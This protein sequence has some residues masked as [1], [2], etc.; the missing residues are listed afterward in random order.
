MPTIGVLDVLRIEEWVPTERT[1]FVR[2]QDRRFP[3]DQLRRDGIFELYQRYQGRPIFHKTDYIVSFYAGPQT[4]A[5]FYGVFK[6]NGH[7]PANEGEVLADYP[8]SQRWHDSAK[9]FYDLELLPHARGLRDRL[10]I[11]WGKGTRSWVQK[12]QNRE[13]L[14]IRE[15][16]RSLPPF[17]DYLEFTLSYRQLQDLFRHPEAHHEWRSRLSA[18]AGVYLI[19][20]ETTGH[21]Y[22]GSATGEAGIWGRWNS[23]ATTGHAG[24]SKLRALLASDHAYPDAFRF[25]ILQ[26]LSRTMA[27]EEV[28]EREIRFKQKLGTRATGLN[29]N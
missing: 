13:V 21:Q 2:H 22:V 23:Y 27:R 4:R 14:E 3:V 11:D 24:N 8:W 18:V 15:P 1:R 16:G 19:L 28:I 7:A 6:V 29:D 26:I 25:S 20:A 9:Y 10:V 12:S 5:I 17:D